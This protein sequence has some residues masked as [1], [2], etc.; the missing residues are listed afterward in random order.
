MAK[1][2]DPLEGIER[3]EYGRVES[4]DPF[5][6]I[7]SVKYE[8]APRVYPQPAAQS[9]YD[10]SQT[11]AK[12]RGYVG[13]AARGTYETAGKV[14]G[15]TGS[16]V[17]MFPS[18]AARA[19]EKVEQFR[20]GVRNWQ[21]ERRAEK[22]EDLRAQTEEQLLRQ[23]MAGERRENRLGELEVRRREMDLGMAPR[24]Q[25]FGSGM[26]SRSVNQPPTGSFLTGGSQFT[27]RMITGG[28]MFTGRGFAGGMFGMRQPEVPQA[29]P[30]IVYRYR[31]KK[32]HVKHK[33]KR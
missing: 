29:K 3:V 21:T 25:G 24:S 32:R 30:K 11:V 13:G 16:A 2:Q 19:A 14:A 10:I 4:R 28:S 6:G 8:S 7:E 23:Q 22:L 1:K 33:R 20:K 27:G 5:E 26:L 15:A 12:V 18:K 31:A 17:R 9:R